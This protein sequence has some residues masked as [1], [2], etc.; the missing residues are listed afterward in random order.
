LMAVSSAILLLDLVE[1]PRSALARA[2]SARPLVRAGRISYGLYL[3]HW[4]IF[5][6][7]T[8]ALV[9]LS[10]PSLNL[11]RFATTW[12]L[13]ELSFALIERPALSWKRSWR[14]V[15]PAPAGGKAR[16]SSSPATGSGSA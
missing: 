14:S 4:P 6:A 13:A 3:W 12:A 10:S 8:P 9:N 16:P 15:A 1:R 7:L 2:L 11:L 5:L